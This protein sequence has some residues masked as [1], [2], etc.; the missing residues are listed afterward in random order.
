M[1][2]ADVTERELPQIQ[3]PDARMVHVLSRAGGHVPIGSP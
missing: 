1:T 2:D 3:P